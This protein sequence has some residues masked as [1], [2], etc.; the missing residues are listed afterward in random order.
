[1]T[2]RQHQAVLPGARRGK[3]P[4]P[5]PQDS[6]MESP[7]ATREQVLE[8]LTAAA[9]R[10]NVPAMRLLLDE[11]RV[12]QANGAGRGVIDELAGKRTSSRD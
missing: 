12:E 1:M 7:I 3:N 2:L 5:D 8:L 9:R 10:G 6:G 4:C 11:L